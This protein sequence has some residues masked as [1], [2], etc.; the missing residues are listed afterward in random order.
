MVNLSTIIRFVEEETSFYI[1]K[2]LLDTTEMS[3]PTSLDIALFSIKTILKQ[4]L[5]QQREE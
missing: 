5:S 1:Y 2:L 4:S 3:L